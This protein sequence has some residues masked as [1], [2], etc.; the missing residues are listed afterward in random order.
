MVSEYIIR[1]FKY[2]GRYETIRDV[3]ASYQCKNCNETLTKKT[4]HTYDD[5]GFTSIPEDFLAQHLMNCKNF[6]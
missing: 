1:N 4:F 2:L 3:V 5:V 6:K